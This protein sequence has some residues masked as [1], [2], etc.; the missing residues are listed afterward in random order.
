MFKNRSYIIF[1]LLLFFVS[2]TYGQIIKTRLDFVGGISAREY[3][4]GG[5]RYQYTDFTQLGAFFGGDVGAYP[6]AITTWS[7]DHMIHF[8]NN[9]FYTNR[10]AWYARQGYTQVKSIAADRI[11]H[12]SYIN[13]AAGR[14]FG[15]TNWLGVNLDLGFILQVRERQEWKAPNLDDIYNGRWYWLPLFRVQ[16]FFSI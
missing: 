14:E 6:E 7:L 13:L 11:Y 5:I 16:V 8:G 9:G 15:I 4:H 1:I 3:L 2:G 10:P 12:F